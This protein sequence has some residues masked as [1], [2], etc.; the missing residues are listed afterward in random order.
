MQKKDDKEKF[1]RKKAVALSYDAAED[2][3]PKVLAKGAGH[4]AEKIIEKG[5]EEALPVYQ[6]EKLVN[7]LTR[8][9]IGDNIPPEL[10]EIVAQ[11]LIFIGDLD[12][13]LEG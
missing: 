6:D 4:L 9:D 2:I 13:K 1:K 12:K 7:D 8:L 11:V 5:K 10:Y 3:S